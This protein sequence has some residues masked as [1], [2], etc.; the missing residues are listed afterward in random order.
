MIGKIYA[1]ESFGAVDGPGVR[2]VVFMQGCPLRCK[3]CHNPDS[4]N[5][6]DF[7]K[8]F[9]AQGMVKEIAKY[10]NFFKKSGGVTFTGGEPMV[11]AKFLLEVLPLCKEKDYHVAIDTSGYVFNDDA[12]AVLDIADLVL[13]DIKSIDRDTYKNLTGVEI[14]NTLEFAKYCSDNGIPMWLR[15]VL[16]PGYTD[17]DE[18]LNALAEFISTLKT[19]EKV[20]LLPYHKMGTVKWEYVGKEDPLKDTEPPTD[21]RVKNARDIILKHNLPLH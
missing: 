13:L 11:Q 9:D 16:V 18:Q 19:V 21:E 15:H 5:M 20:E 10:E 7:K 12:K 17:F 4:W 8:E 14:D 1:T 2:Y 3:Y 6:S